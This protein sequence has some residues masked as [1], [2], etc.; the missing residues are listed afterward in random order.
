MIECAWLY[1]EHTE[2]K[3]SSGLILHSD[4]GRQYVSFAFQKILSKHHLLPSMSRKGN[5]YDNACAES[6][7]KTLKME[8]VYHERYQTRQEAHSS[9]F[10]YIE[11]FYNRVR[12]HSSLGYLS[13][14]QF[15]RRACLVAS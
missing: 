4:R 5:C 3:S 7:F 13:P 8:L 11:H 9:L 10:E 14:E 2:S 1:R 6:F 15:E 12:L